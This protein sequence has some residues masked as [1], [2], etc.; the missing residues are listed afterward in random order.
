MFNTKTTDG[1]E[2]TIL[3]YQTGQEY[4]IIA[5]FR[6]QKGKWLPQ[7]YNMKGE[8]FKDSKNPLNLVPIINI[9]PKD[10][11]CRVYSNGYPSLTNVLRYSNGVGGFFAAGVDSYSNP[12]TEADN[13]DRCETI[14][15]PIRYWNGE[16]DHPIPDGC[17]FRVYFNGNWTKP[18]RA[19]TYSWNKIGS[20]SDITNFQILGE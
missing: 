15:N 7:S 18:T 10:V 5:M 3:A 16:G 12:D 19:N 13:W 6:T 17:L 9:L 20:K 8:V 2:V 11:L 14:E 4:P 1:N